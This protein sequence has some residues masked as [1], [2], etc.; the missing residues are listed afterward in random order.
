[1][2]RPGAS[3]R[4]GAPPA[5]PNSFVPR[6]RPGLPSRRGRIIGRPH[7]RAPDRSTLA[8]YGGSDFAVTRMAFVRKGFGTR[9]APDGQRVSTRWVASSAGTASVTR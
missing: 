7:V 3:G 6:G 5:D 9:S 1:M 8:V 2:T 4:S